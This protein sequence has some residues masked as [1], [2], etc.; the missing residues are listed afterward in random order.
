MSFWELLS[1]FTQPSESIFKYW[2][3]KEAKIWKKEGKKK[4]IALDLRIAVF[5][6]SN[7]SRV[8]QLIMLLIEL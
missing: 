4:R 3:R 6:L 7:R 5:T 8:L 2:S 1:I